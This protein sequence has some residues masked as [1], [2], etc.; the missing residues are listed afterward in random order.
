MSLGECL[1]NLPSGGRCYKANPDYSP[2]LT[3]PDQTFYDSVSNTCISCYPGCSKCTSGGMNGCSECPSGFVLKNGACTCESWEI[4][5]PVSNTCISKFSQLFFLNLQCY[6]VNCNIADCD[7]CALFTDSSNVTTL[8]CAQCSAGFYYLS[9][10]NTCT[11]TCPTDYYANTTTGTCILINC[12]AD[13]YNCPDCTSCANTTHCNVCQGSLFLED[14]VCVSSCVTHPVSFNGICVDSCSTGYGAQIQG[15]NSVCV[16]CDPSCKTCS[17]SSYDTCLTC[18]TGNYIS[19]GTCLSCDASCKDCSGTAANCTSCSTGNYLFSGAS[20]NCVSSCPATY[21]LNDIDQMCLECAEPLALT[22]TNDCTFCGGNCQVCSDSGLCLQCNSG[23]QL[24]NGYCTIPGMSSSGRYN[25]G[26]IKSIT[27]IALLKYSTSQTVMTAFSQDIQATSNFK[28]VWLLFAEGI[29]PDY[30]SLSCN[31]IDNFYLNNT[32]DFPSA[33]VQIGVDGFQYLPFAESYGY[34]LNFTGLRSG[35]NYNFT[36]CVMQSGIALWESGSVEFE[37]K[38][39]GYQIQKV[40]ITTDNYLPQS[41]ITNFLCSLS[42]SMNVSNSSIITSEGVACNTAETAARRNLADQFFIVPPQVQKKH[43]QPI[44]NLRLMTTVSKYQGTKLDLLIYGNQSEQTDQTVNTAIS[45][46]TSTT[47][48]Q[49]FTYRSPTSGSIKIFRVS[50][51]GKVFMKPPKSEGSNTP[52]EIKGNAVFFPN[53][54]FTNTDGYLYIYLIPNT[55]SKST[56]PS[57][58]IILSSIYTADSSSNQSEF[59]VKRFKFFSGE[60]LTIIIEDAMANVTYNVA[61]FATNEDVS[62]FAFRTPRTM[63][64]VITGLSLPAIPREVSIVI[65]TIMEG[66]ALLFF[67]LIWYFLYKPFKISQSFKKLRRKR[68]TESVKPR[69][70]DSP[71]ENAKEITLQKAPRNPLDLGFEKP[72]KNNHSTN[73]STISIPNPQKEDKDVMRM[74]SDAEILPPH[75]FAP[76]Q[77]SPMLKRKEAKNYIDLTK[78]AE[79]TKERGTPKMR[80]SEDRSTPTF[81]RFD[82]Q[83]NQKR[84]HFERKSFH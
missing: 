55:S 51:G 59:I 57:S 12:A 35:V 45:L 76:T 49:S 34:Y 15:A 9:S 25:T 70:V 63:F 39:N 38:D 23:L 26:V 62:P 20:P 43:H 10:S 50:L 42:S 13:C 56:L 77:S 75:I 46:L 18:N 84:M 21:Y 29:A 80:K 14:G 28:S 4:L 48:T 7:T 36:I 68:T 33:V 31:D 74:P 73:I 8:I 78:I 67:I 27:S 11:Q 83:G 47:F 71:K 16:P 82:T 37:T 53:F 41:E 52:Y 58:P 19:A 69:R 1:W 24:T 5:D 22:A 61:L 6:L 17:S 44:P 66:S 72:K 30:Q 54:T 40:S 65:F 32:R 79:K 64:Q 81:I 60:P 2:V 3:C